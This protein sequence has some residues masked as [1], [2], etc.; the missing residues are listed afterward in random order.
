MTESDVPGP[1]LGELR[2]AGV[3]AHVAR[4]GA[5]M[6]AALSGTRRGRLM[7]R[8]ARWY[9]RRRPATRPEGSSR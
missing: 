5:Q 3:E 2:A 1:T 4:L 9:A 7:L 8:F 6:D